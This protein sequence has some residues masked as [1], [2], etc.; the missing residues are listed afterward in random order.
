MLALDAR[1]IAL[2]PAVLTAKL[3]EARAELDEL[4]HDLRVWRNDDLMHDQIKAEI[5][6]QESYIRY[7]EFQLEQAAND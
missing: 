6:V 5:A 7:L 3:D 1:R 2:S 4:A